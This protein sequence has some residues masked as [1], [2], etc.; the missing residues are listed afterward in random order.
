MH[1]LCAM[2]TKNL[3]FYFRSF[4]LH[5]K[6]EVYSREFKNEFRLCRLSSKTFE[7]VLINSFVKKLEIGFRIIIIIE[8]LNRLVSSYISIWC[9]WLSIYHAKIWILIFLKIKSKILSN[10]GLQPWV[11]LGHQ[12]LENNKILHPNMELF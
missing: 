11:L 6:S 4:L 8:T 1:F 5:C 12:R 2:V 3:D 10:L 9:I 7:I